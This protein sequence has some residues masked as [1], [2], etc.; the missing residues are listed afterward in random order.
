MGRPRKLNLSEDSADCSH[1]AIC[2]TIF[3]YTPDYSD[4]TS[5]TKTFYTDST[6]YDL[7]SPKV[8]AGQIAARLDKRI[9]DVII[10][11]ITL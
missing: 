1:V 5:I 4:R 8:I 3:E 10:T 11:R 2:V 7:P 6:L 9:E